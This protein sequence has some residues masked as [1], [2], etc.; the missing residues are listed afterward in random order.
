MKYHGVV[1]WITEYL[2]I[3]LPVYPVV[4]SLTL[5]FLTKYHIRHPPTTTIAGFC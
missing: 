4:V 3:L 1:R 2:S 5:V